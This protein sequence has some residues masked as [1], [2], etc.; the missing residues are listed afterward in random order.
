M[1]T[2]SKF[3]EKFTFFSEE[4]YKQKFPSKKLISRVLT[5]L[6]EVHKNL[7]F[8]IGQK[9]KKREFII[10]ADGIKEAFPVVLKLVEH[11]P[12][13]DRWH[14]IAF[15]QRKGKELAISL[16]GEEFVT[17][18]IFFSYVF[19]KNKMDI[20]I[21]I[22]KGKEHKA[23]IIAVFIFLD[24]LIGEYDVETKIGKIEIKNLSEI[25]YERKYSLDDLPD[26]LDG[27]FLKRID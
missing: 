10:S 15:R 14:I 26:I 23:N 20:T 3:W 16:K 22:K 25:S 5:C 11:A 8:E 4:L 13:F 12:H 7:Y 6:Q 17:K 9:A 18:E 27:L 24:S 19:T 2:Y 1:N 21:Y